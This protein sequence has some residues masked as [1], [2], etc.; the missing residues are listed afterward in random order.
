MSETNGQPTP[1]IPDACGAR[2]DA[3]DGELA[4]LPDPVQTVALKWRAAVERHGRT[5]G[6]FLALEEFVADLALA[7]RQLAA[8][9]LQLPP[10]PPL[11]EKVADQTQRGSGW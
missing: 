6:H 10:D 7:A 3:V 8:Q 4:S 1:A 5:T 11:P 9:A 2:Q